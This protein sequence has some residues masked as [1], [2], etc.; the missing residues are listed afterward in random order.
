MSLRDC[1]AA[2]RQASGET[3]TDDEALELLEEVQRR[4]ARILAEG[5]LD[6]LDERVREAA[7][8]AADEARLAAAIQRK[9]AALNAIVRDRLE[10][11]I[12]GMLDEGLDYRKAV[13][14][15]LEGSPRNIG[16]ARVSVAATKLAFEGRFIGDMMAEIQRE[17]PQVLGMLRDR[18]FLDDVVREMFELR[19]G[20]SPGRTGNADAAFSAK[21][22][23]RYA[24]ISRQDLNRLGAVIGK[25]DGWAGPQVHDPY[26]LMRSSEDEWIAAI[27]PR[28]DLARTFPDVAEPQEHVRILRE[29]YKTIVTGRDLSVTAREK[30]GFTAPANLARSLARHRVLHFKSADDWLAYNEAYGHGHIVTAMLAHQAKAA[31][32]AAQ[33]QVLGPNPEVML[34][35]V[36][37]SLQKRA[38]GDERLS[39]AKRA[40]Q[41][42]ALTLDGQGSIAAAFAEMSGLTLTPASA[43]AAEIGSGIRALQSMAK[44]GGAVVSSVTDLVT[45]AEALHYQGKPLLQT[46][47]DQLGDLFRGRGSA[48]QRELAYLLGEGYDGIVGHIVSP[49]VAGDAPLGF[50]SRAL[51]TF[52]RWSGLTWWTDV[53]RA[54]QARMLA[55]WAGT[56]VGTAY[57]E[58]DD[59]YRRVLRQHGI[60][61]AE[62]DAIRQA[63]WRSDDNGRV[64]VTPDRVRELPDDVIDDYLAASG[65]LEPVEGE[66]GRAAEA[67]AVDEARLERLRE[68]ARFE[69]ELALRRFF[70]DETGFGVIETDPAARRATLQGTQPG[71]VTGEALRFIAQ[72]KGYPI[73]FTQRVVGRAVMGGE[74]ATL[75]ERLISS[76]GN[77]GHLIAG[78][79]VFGYGAMTAKDI[80]AGREPRDPSRPATILAALQQGGGLGIYGDFLFG[81]ASRFGNTVLE[82]VAGPSFGAA[83]NLIRWAQLARDGEARGGE[84]LNIALQNTPFINLW[85]TR[86]ALDV[87]VL[88]ALRDALSPGFL[89]RQER[90]R[91]KEFGQEFFLPRTVF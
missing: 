91:R 1:I 42:R 6:R 51:E 17:R 40:R 14:A 59:A 24:E 29:I 26:R 72:F 2:V 69:L 73:A 41:V 22:F 71:T 27:L 50:M 60:G 36:L 75:G 4:R 90:Q 68:T 57:D 5:K 15:I 38:R 8:Q 86:P 80:L 48:E 63:R 64:Y 28:L 65:R 58:L 12:A 30:G 62:W 10:T 82:T 66:A 52:F 53:M 61:A 25:L 7:A 11:Q 70:A 32:V 79:T 76:A 83:A 89:A 81:Q 74:G 18:A 39:M 16:G 34:G 9:H 35:A 19:D 54:G 87:L 3:L 84:L 47:A 55:A 23:A 56:K 45:R 33:M 31:R 49:Y 88:N 85:Y 46:W 77:I 21:T 20:G 37:E 78:L 44:L 67:G 13:L 43:G